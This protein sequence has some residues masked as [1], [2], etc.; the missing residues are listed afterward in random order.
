MKLTTVPSGTGEV[1]W[2]TVAR[3]STASPVTAE[4]A[5]TVKVRLA[6]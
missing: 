2:R 4:L 3:A 6:A 1:P 5:E